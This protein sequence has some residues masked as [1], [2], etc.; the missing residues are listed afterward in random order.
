MASRYSTIIIGAIILA[1]GLAIYYNANFFIFEIVDY[2][3]KPP[4]PQD[5]DTAD[6]DFLFAWADILFLILLPYLL[7]LSGI[8]IL[9]VGG[10][11]LLQKSI[12]K[13]RPQIEKQSEQKRPQWLR[14]LIFISFIPIIFGI[15]ATIFDVSY[16]YNN[17][18]DVFIIGESNSFDV[19]HLVS[20]SI[21]SAIA[22]QL[23]RGTWNVRT[24]VVALLVFDTFLSAIYF[25]KGSW[26]HAGSLVINSF[27]IYYLFKPKVQQY[28]DSKKTERKMA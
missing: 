13:K 23:I 11:K 10:I 3:T 18:I 21:W 4:I 8:I 17:T 15:I 9:I 19:I 25:I 14:N 22:Y 5:L 24:T 28:F 1:V 20:I 12:I 7:I 16:L 6:Y 27:I 26:Y 2:S